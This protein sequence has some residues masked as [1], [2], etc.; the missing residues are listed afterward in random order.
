M[1]IKEELKARAT[2]LD[3]REDAVRAKEADVEAHDKAIAE[4]MASL[5]QQRKQMEGIQAQI[6]KRHGELKELDK[7]ILSRKAELEAKAEALAAR[8][9]DIAAQLQKLQRAQKDFESQSHTL[10]EKEKEIKRWAIDAMNREKELGSKAKEM[11]DWEKRLSAHDREVSAKLQ[12]LAKREEDLRAREGLLNMQ[13]QAKGIDPAQLAKEGKKFLD[14]QKIQEGLLGRERQLAKLEAEV[15]SKDRTLQDMMSKAKGAEDRALARLEEAKRKEGELANR[16]KGLSD[17]E[18]T[19]AAK[20][21]EVERQLKAANEALSIAKDKERKY[22]DLFKDLHSKSASV[23]ANQEE[24]KRIQQEMAA[25]EK[26]YGEVELKLR[27][28][29]EI[30]TSQRKELLELQKD[31]EA[32]E[33]ELNLRQMEMDKKMKEGVQGAPDMVRDKEKA[34]EMWER[35]LKEKEQEIKNRLY[36]K[37][38]ELEMRERALQQGLQRDLSEQADETVQ[39]VKA[40]KIRTG[41][42]RLDDLLLG[43]LPMNSHILFVGPAFVGKE[44]GILNFIAEGLKK[45][46]PAVIIT[47]TKPPTEVAKEMGPIL[48]TYIQYEQLGLVKWID[49]SGSTEAKRT[50]VV[51]NSRYIVNGAADFNGIINALNMI[52]EDFRGKYPYFRLAFMTLSTC[53][54][55]GGDK[56]AMG[57]VQKLINRLRQAKCVAIYAVER[58]MHS[59]QQIE[60]VEH[61][62]DGAIHF[63]VDR[64][65]N[66]LL[67]QGLGE[68]QTRDWVEYKFSNRGLMIGSF[69]LERIR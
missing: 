56:E 69:M 60:A 19:L 14:L 6:N 52:D 48:P 8:E 27:K 1:E 59:D 25:K 50:P 45:G 22:L 67:V 16:E 17:R 35:R 53:I 40:D 41:T 36:Q 32:K 44:V 12:E 47:T 62:A 30:L 28:E 26:R 24:V 10:V 18:S 38:K 61:Q 31:L 7:S 46:V 55:Q 11:E 37:E 21:K 4:R 20:V 64:Q 54:T 63:K 65:K 23:V 68:V 13:I 2:A 51:Q 57:F 42:Q 43:G 15:R 39:E 5:E 58:G 34:L 9:R 66:M 29:M 49:A 33:S 3:Y